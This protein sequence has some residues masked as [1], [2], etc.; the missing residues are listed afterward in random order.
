[1]QNIRRACCLAA[2]LRKYSVIRNRSFE[3]KGSSHGSGFCMCGFCTFGKIPPPTDNTILKYDEEDPFS[4]INPISEDTSATIDQIGMETDSQVLKNM[5]L[6]EMID[7]LQSSKVV[8]DVELQNIELQNEINKLKAQLVKV[9]PHS[10]RSNI[11]KEDPD[12]A[13]LLQH[14]KNWVRT[15][16]EQ[17]KNFFKRIG[18]P[19]KPKYL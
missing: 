17:D 5:K 1:M 11:L 3:F 4:Q 18:G 19:Q 16:T 13:L 6:Q 9:D 14:N 10:I 12:I 2:N 7:K 8:D 15:Q